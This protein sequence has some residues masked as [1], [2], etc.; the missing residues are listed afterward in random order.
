M[1]SG[2]RLAGK[3]AVITGGASGIGR[4]I[5]HRFVGEGASVV[6]GDLN[7]ALLA[8]ATTALG[9]DRCATHALDVREEDGVEALAALAVE[10][11]GRLDIGVNCAGVGTMSPITE[12]PVEEFERVV[13][14]CLKGVFL[15][16]KHEARRMR[17]LGV[18]GVIVNIASINARQP[19]EG[20]VAYCA[21]KAG[22]EMLTRVAAMELARHDIRVC[23]IA[24]GFV[25]TPLT[26]F[27]RDFPAVRDGYL[28]N[29]PM[30]RAGAPEDIAAAALFLAGPEAS[31][32]SGET[33]AVD[34][35]SLTREYPRF[36]DIFGVT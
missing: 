2:E 19:G 26:Q 25:D 3:V 12:H 4:A 13:D 9:A 10:R 33:L 27:S 31:W 7:E 6:L 16:V 30:G 18:G 15:S 14:I 28:Q 11:F 21:A 29:I 32:V 8:E 17:E 1:E 20:M 34:G 24:P 23:G 22:V 36:F 35:A 5:A